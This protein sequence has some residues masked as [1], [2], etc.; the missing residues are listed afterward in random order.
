MEIRRFSATDTRTAMRRVRSEMGADAVILSTR[1]VEGG[2]ELVSA[3]DY[4]PEL[5][6]GF[7][8]AQ[9][10]STERTPAQEAPPPDTD[11]VV[12]E[13]HRQLSATVRDLRLLLE[14]EA[15]RQPLPATVAA[16]P[17][18]AA[19][20]T[21][22]ADSGFAPQAIRRLL[23]Q[24]PDAK[25]FELSPSQLALAL[26]KTLGTDV[27][28]ELETG[29]VIAVVGPTGVGK[30]TTVAKLAVRL[31]ARYSSNDIALVST[32]F[33]RLGA[34]QQL[35]SLG[36]LLAMPV[37]EV[38]DPT[39]LDGLVPVLANRRW[40]IVDTAGSGD[41]AAR[42]LAI[43]RA[44]ARS[45]RA[46]KTLLALAGNAQPSF[47]SAVLASHGT[48]LAATVALTKIDECV[49]LGPTLS[50]LIKHARPLGIGTTGP[51]IPDD[52]VAGRDVPLLVARHALGTDPCISAGFDIS[53]KAHERR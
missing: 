15:R 39:E 35:Q 46:V 8:S 53:E 11:T 42:A 50:T 40:V 45:D 27:L 5:L 49:A 32:D 14:R 17:Q 33:C 36:R 47:N 16:T 38:D 41:T 6:S 44:F 37:F 19:C 10:N 30:T 28:P 4:D 13:T 52:L 3:S 1:P 34:H 51:T 22:L 9:T 18:H 25:E 21:Q 29:G 23:A 31:A 12:D 24:L 2:V 43:Q 7:A 48:A 20:A 26:T